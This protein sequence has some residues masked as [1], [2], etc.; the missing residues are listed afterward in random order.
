MLAHEARGASLAGKPRH[1][2][3]AARGGRGARLRATPTR[4]VAASAKTKYGL[5]DVSYAEL[6]MADLVGA[7]GAAVQGSAP[8]PVG[9]PGKN[10][11]LMEMLPFLF[12]LVGQD[13]RL[14][15]RFAAAIGAVVISKACSLASPLLFKQ[16]VDALA[17]DGA[18]VPALGLKTAV[19]ALLLAGALTSVGS[20]AN[21]LRSVLF[22][23]VAQAA[24]RR[25]SM[26]TFEHVLQ[27]DPAFH[28]DRSTGAMSRVLDRGARATATIFRAVLFTF[29]PTAVEFVLVC[30]LLAR[31]VSW[32]LAGAVV[33]TFATYI[34]YTIA[35]T[36]RS[37]EIRKEVNRLDNL[38]SGKTVDALLNVD[39]VTTF[40]NEAIE[41]R[42]VNL[43][44]RQFAEA[45]VRAEYA[46]ATLNGG[47]GVIV[48]LG[49]A[50][51]LCIAAIKCA[52]GQATPGDVV[53]VNGLM[54]QLWAPLSFLGWFYRNLRQAMVD[55]ENLFAI[56]R[57][58]PTLRSG[59][60][61]LPAAA[62]SGAGV[63]LRD[64]HFRYRDSIPVLRGVDL[65][66]K[67]GESVAIVGPSGSGKSTLTK[68]LLR[69]YD[70]ES[71]SVRVDGLDVT[72]V[73]PRALREAVGLVPQDAVLFNA[74]LRYN[75][76]YGRPE[77]DDEE[78]RKA[79][80]AASLGPL[81][82]SLPEGLDTMVGERGLKLSGGEKQRVAVAR[83][84]L[85]R[86]R[87]LLCD[88]ATAA[89][90]TATEAAV[91]ASLKRAGRGRT[92][93]LVAHRLSTV[94][95]CDRIYVLERGRVVESGTHDELV[96]KPGG[97]YRA[98]W[99][100]QA[101]GL[102]DLEAEQEEK[103]LRALKEG[104]FADGDGADAATAA[105]ETSTS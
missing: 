6:S 46:Q 23:P 93:L 79:I 66:A 95:H 65:I 11:S 50:A 10:A 9:V 90:D 91:S 30:W 77:A 96:H 60:L 78:V 18:G 64:V 88:E 38:V 75:V 37:V 17:I 62:T 52:Q 51:V 8:L 87:L 85:R 99:A 7:K 101:E 41:G 27:L 59:T 92:V 83:A 28:L 72:Q 14:W 55:M 26:R 40:T 81:I 103:M 57:E 80:A 36:Q 61:P 5:D 20:V 19:S 97:T 24:G 98:M 35:L 44:Q 63:E 67:P 70:A 15:L 34:A 1:G 53:L 32:Q 33:A 86:P 54:L 48:C 16:A 4:R 69:Q 56:L 12:K 82:E 73:A 89:L 74:T 71:G 49:L 2:V 43:L 25:V 104:H 105:A 29:V 102:S 100:L 13:R 22:T 45:S 42:A 21:E 94:M 76:Q 39:T 3:R 31:T 58:R 68:L 84:I 47:Q